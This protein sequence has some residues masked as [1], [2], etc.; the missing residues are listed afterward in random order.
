MVMT[1]E[2]K[3]A[4]QRQYY[5]SKRDEILQKRREYR[6]RPEVQEKQ[7]KYLIR[8]YQRKLA[9]MQQE[10]QCNDKQEF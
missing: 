6:K 9:K 4:K 10:D 2:E 8:H 5:E 3:K 1:V 7:K